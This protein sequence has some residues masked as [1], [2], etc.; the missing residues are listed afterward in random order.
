MHFWL[1][2]ES[3]ADLSKK[4]QADVPVSPRFKPRY[5]RLTRPCLR[6]QFLLRHISLLP[7]FNHFSRQVE[8][9]SQRLVFTGELNFFHGGCLHLFYCNPFKLCQDSPPD[10]AS[11]TSSRARSHV[12]A[13]SAT[14]HKSARHDVHRLSAVKEKQAT[15]SIPAL[16][17]QF[18]QTFLV[19]Y[20]LRV[21]L[22][23]KWPHILK[24][25]DD[26]KHSCAQLRFHLSYEILRLFYDSDFIGHTSKIYH[27]WYLG[28]SIIHVSPP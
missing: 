4:S 23:H 18:M 2:S 15:T 28:K 5:R 17:T 21:R 20:L 25:T 16:Y 7:Q 24:Q 13:F 14:L 10:T 3:F 6:S 9:I 12:A 22:S 8:F 1:R 27:I 26:P 19:L 11:S